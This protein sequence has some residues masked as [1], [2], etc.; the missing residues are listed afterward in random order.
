MSFSWFGRHLNTVDS[1]NFHLD[2]VSYAYEDGRVGM[3]GVSVD[4]FAQ[5]GHTA[6][7]GLNGAGK[8]TLLKVLT[9]RFA[10]TGGLMTATARD[11]ADSGAEETFRS[12]SK[13]DRRRIGM[14]A[15][16]VE[17]EEIPGEFNTSMSIHDALGA[18]LKKYRLGETERLAVIG[19]MFA[20]FD[21]THVARTPA[22]EL[23]TEQLHMLALAI[24]C[25]LNPAVLVADEPTRG[26]D[27]I[28]T[29]HVAQALFSC[30]KPVIFATHDVDLLTRP[31]YHIARTLVMDDGDVRF[32]GLP[33]DA[34]A[35]Y[36]D[37]IRGKYRAM[38]Q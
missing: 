3:V 7:I 31:E 11:G 16:Y 24:A 20:H 12:D 29:G 15:G 21:L 10:P 14:F 4:L 30:E 35:F 36:A 34:A 27:E 2:D 5:D 1:A 19:N 38:R 13:R 37:L 33:E 18:L 32:D 26:L 9:G 8:S 6:V 22:R 23:D 17:R 25:A 28:S